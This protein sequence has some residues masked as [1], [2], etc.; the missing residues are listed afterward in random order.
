MTVRGELEG[1]G[2]L[3]PGGPGGHIHHSGKVSRGVFL[4]IRS[5]YSKEKGKEKYAR[6]TKMGCGGEQ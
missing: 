1:K 4:H 2:G 6:I 5:V 3:L